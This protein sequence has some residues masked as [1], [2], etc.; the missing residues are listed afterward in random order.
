MNFFQGSHYRAYRRAVPRVSYAGLKMM[1]L[2]RT[3][4]VALLLGALG[5]GT[6]ALA[7]PIITGSNSSLVGQTLN[8]TNLETIDLTSALGSTH[9][10]PALSGDLVLTFTQNAPVASSSVTAFGSETNPN[11]FIITE[12]DTVTT[13]STSPQSSATVSIGGSNSASGAAPTHTIM[14][15]T[16]V[17]TN[18]LPPVFFGGHEFLEVDT[19]V[20]QSDTFSG[21]FTIDIALTDTE[22]LALDTNKILSFSIAG[23]N[24][25]EI[26]ADSLNIHFASPPVPVP[27]P[28]IFA[29]LSFGLAGIGFGRRRTPP[30]GLSSAQA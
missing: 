24:S 27:A 22:L 16:A 8:G 28:G 19:L 10:G 20:N 18:N 25:P 15:L 23:F 3:V 4:K 30:K 9:V 5:L 1:N 6:Q 13:T 12:R 26:T 11:N 29:L 17:G 2:K 7:T 21:S 14:P